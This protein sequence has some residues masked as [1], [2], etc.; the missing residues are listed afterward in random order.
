MD[1]K[2]CSPLSQSDVVSPFH[3]FAFK[4]FT[5]TKYIAKLLYFSVSGGPPEAPKIC[6]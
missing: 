3:R 6:Y 4:A 5:G 1:Y 2:A